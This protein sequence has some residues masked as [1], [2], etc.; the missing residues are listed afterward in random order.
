MARKRPLFNSFV[1]RH[2]E[3]ALFYDPSRRGWE[4]PVGLLPLTGLFAFFTFISYKASSDLSP[5]MVILWFSG[6][7]I[8]LAPFYRVL[9]YKDDPL[10]RESLIIYDDEFV[11][12]ANGDAWTFGLVRLKRDEYKVEV[13]AR[14]AEVYDLEKCD[15]YYVIVFNKRV[16][17]INFVRI[18]GD[19]GVWEDNVDEVAGLLGAE[20]RLT[21]GLYYPTVYA[22]FKEL[23]G[24]PELAEKLLKDYTSE[25]NKYGLW[26]V[27][28]V[29]NALRSLC[30]AGKKEE[31]VKL[32]KQITTG[33]VY[34]KI[35]RIDEREYAEAYAEP[36]GSC[37]PEKGDNKLM[38]KWDKIM[39]YS[40]YSLGTLTLV[41]AALF[42]FFSLQ[43]S[44]STIAAFPI[45]A[46]LV[47][48]FTR[49]PYFSRAKL[50]D[51]YAKIVFAAAAPFTVPWTLQMFAAIFLAKLTTIW[52]AIYT[53]IVTIPYLL[54]AYDTLVF[55]Q[56]YAYKIGLKHAKQLLQ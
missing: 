18:D 48:G 52:L 16:R 36:G 10:A 11:I 13:I 43:L 29:M 44:T 38:R 46:T 14:D 47:F 53:A 17:G 22:I 32:A 41:S 25:I 45:M 35:D 50:G 24:E 30:L 6:A 8:T 56:Y 3:R 37:Y 19:H 31:A 21:K 54:I 1:F 2:G 7:V 23:C 15:K 27:S 12:G 26:K 4:W 33:E 20:K 55:T 28:A 5:F 42:P 51:S 49:L 9:F 40:V 39:T 34:E